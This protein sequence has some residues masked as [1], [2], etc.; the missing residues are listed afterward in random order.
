MSIVSLSQFARLA[1]D[2]GLQAWVDHYN[3]GRSHMAL[4][5]GV[6]DP[7]S[8]VEPSGTPLARHRIGERPRVHARSVLGGLHHQYQLSPALA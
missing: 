2:A 6:P 5:P 3:H 4:G 1:L 8:G 7:P